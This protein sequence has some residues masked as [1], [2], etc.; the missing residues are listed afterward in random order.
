[1]LR[2]A[3][4]PYPRARDAK[5][6]QSSAAPVTD[7]VAR[8]P[9]AD[10]SAR[11]IFIVTLFKN[12]DGSF[13]K[14]EYSVKAQSAES[15][16]GGKTLKYATYAKTIVDFA[17]HATLEQHSGGT[18]IQMQLDAKA[19]KVRGAEVEC[20]GHTRSDLERWPLCREE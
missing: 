13:E 3:L 8:W 5:V 7:G 9:A 11:L 17:K 12:A 15:K 4:H 16:D 10:G 6:Q 20:P 14:K 2:G 18:P 1:M 19:S